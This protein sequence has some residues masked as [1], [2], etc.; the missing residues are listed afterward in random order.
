[1]LLC[2]SYPLELKKRILSD[3]GHL[4]NEDCVAL[5]RAV[6]HEKLKKIILAHLSEENNY[7]AIALETMKNGLMDMWDLESD[8]PE[9]VVAD[10]REPIPVISTE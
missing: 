6:R 5:V 2:G 9:I 1:M 8:I 10:R 4:S 7:P 3:F